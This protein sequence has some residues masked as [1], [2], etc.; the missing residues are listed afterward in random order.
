M[1]VAI[2]RLTGADRAA[3]V[4]MRRTLYVEEA[5]DDD[6]GI[7]DIDMMLRDD[8]WAALTAVAPAWRRRGIARQLIAAGM[9]WGRS[10]GRTEMASDVQLANL[11]SQAMHEALG[12]EETERLVTYRMDI[13]RKA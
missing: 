6:V 9:D 1:S 10:R 8:A 7:D 4:A 3:W 12:F 11:R 2:R 13:P 5:G